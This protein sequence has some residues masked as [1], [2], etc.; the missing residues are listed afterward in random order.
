MSRLTVEQYIFENIEDK[1]LP[2]APKYT[3]MS[4]YLTCPFPLY[5][6]TPDL[7]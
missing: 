4:L 5:S 2:P 6:T 7:P 1:T 3:R